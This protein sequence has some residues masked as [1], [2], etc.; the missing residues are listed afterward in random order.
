MSH[1]QTQTSGT[2]AAY[3]RRA[4][5]SEHEVASQ[6]ALALRLAALLDRVLEDPAVNTRERLLA[7]ARER[8]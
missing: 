4:G 5:A 2:V 3:P 8:R 6:E 1:P 7:L